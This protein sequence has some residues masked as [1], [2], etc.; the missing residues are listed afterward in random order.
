[1]GRNAAVHVLVIEDTRHDPEV[2]LTA[3][4]EQA[5]DIKVA[6]V[7]D[8][9]AAQRFLANCE[10]PPNVILLGMQLPDM[11]GIEL[12]RYIRSNDRTKS[13]PVLM[14]IEPEDRTQKNR[15]FGLGVNGYIPHV[16]DATLLADH[17]TIFRHLF[18]GDVN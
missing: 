9:N 1:M 14:L 16:G 15:T 2:T 12:L 6:V 3:L 13:L 11:E 17:L 8:G 5:N 7:N 18:T 4:H 10:I